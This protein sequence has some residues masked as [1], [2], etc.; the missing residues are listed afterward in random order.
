[1][2]FQGPGLQGPT[3]KAASSWLLANSRIWKH[4]WWGCKVR[5]KFVTQRCPPSGDSVSLKHT[6]KQII[7]VV[8][9]EKCKS[10]T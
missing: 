4:L 2:P 5:L 8:S 3:V 9:E 7:V 10:I 6:N 1:M